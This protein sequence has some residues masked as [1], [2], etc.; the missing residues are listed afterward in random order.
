MFVRLTSNT[1]QCFYSLSP[2]VFVVSV[3]LLTMITQIVWLRLRVTNYV[4]DLSNI[5][6]CFKYRFLLW[7]YSNSSP[8]TISLLWWMLSD[9]YYFNSVNGKYV[10]Q[11]YFLEFGYCMFNKCMS[12]LF[13]L[14]IILARW[15]LAVSCLFEQWPK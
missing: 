10:L 2:I 6:Y 11:I 13:C 1:N 4:D 8:S 15:F 12:S 3:S 14:S 7:I 5:R 9:E